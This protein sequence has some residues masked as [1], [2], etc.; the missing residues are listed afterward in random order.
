MHRTK[1]RVT[2]I[3][4][5][6]PAC[7]RQT[8]G[9]AR[10]MPRPAG[11]HHAELSEGFACRERLTHFLSSPPRRQHY[12]YQNPRK[13]AHDSKQETRDDQA[14]C[15][16][17]CID[18]EFVGPGLTSGNA[19]PSGSNDHQSPRGMRRRYAPRGRCLREDAR[20]SRRQQM[21]PRGDLLIY[22]AKARGVPPLGCSCRGIE[23][24]N[25]CDRSGLQ[26]LTFLVS[27]FEG[28][29]HGCRS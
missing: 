27:R 28:P 21:R 19:A 17:S 6:K 24:N 5:L 25:L 29:A 18:P 14:D 2:D 8:L 26:K 10:H 12:G 16:C 9:S 7:C 20:P 23:L 4:R 3:F 15:F 13:A 11:A 1:Y 22:H